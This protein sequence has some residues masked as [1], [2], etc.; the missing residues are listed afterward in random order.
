MTDVHADVCVVG[1]GPAGL[2]LALLLL[3]SG[4]RVAVVERS[5][6]MEREFR[7][8]ILQP[9]GMRVLA[10]LGVLAE[11]TADGHHEHDTFALIEAGRVLMETDYRRFP[12]PFDCLLSVPQAQV[13]GALLR[14]C[15]DHDTCEYLGG[16]RA[17]ELVTGG[18][19]VR[20]VTCHGAHGPRVV[21]AKVVV[22]ADGRYSKVR[23]LAGIDAGR[24]DVFH[25][26]VLWFKLPA[27]GK[28]PRSVTVF[29]E[30]GSSPVMAYATVPDE[31]QFGWTLPHGRYNEVATHGIDH[32]KAALAAAIPP[33]ADLIGQEI[34]SLRDV[35]LLDVFSACAPEWVRDGL[36][37]IGDSAHAHSPIGAQ[38]I[39]VAIQDAVSLHPVLVAAVR[40]GDT[41]AAAL[42]PFERARRPDIERVHRIQLLQSRTMLSAGRVA[43]T[44]RPIAAKVVVRSPMF[45][46]VRDT[47]AFGNTSIAIARDLFTVPHG[48]E[49]QQCD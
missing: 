6:S 19:A 8:E 5:R 9:G 7:G 44:L 43:S 30:P 11:A 10:E 3:R 22:G 46:A 1:G 29:R 4:L 35:S 18:G 12:A 15:L 17:A 45:R 31:I 23:Q 38:G 32:I 16:H 13:L 40:R 20:G 36:V 39:N 24:T 34:T 41:G 47:L 14:R 21:H 28:Q 42:R 37:L 48:N 27:H 33:Y 26:D 25:Q 2:T 49:R